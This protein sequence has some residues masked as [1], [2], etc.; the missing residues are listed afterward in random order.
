MVE[1]HSLPV[2]L[3]SDGYRF[4]R[5]ALGIQGSG[6]LYDL[7]IGVEIAEGFCVF[8]FAAGRLIIVD[9]VAELLRLDKG[10]L[11]EHLVEGEDGG[12]AGRRLACL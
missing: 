1:A 8:V 4:F 12:V 11:G 3:H 7:E 6:L 10:L 2:Q 9:R 5:S